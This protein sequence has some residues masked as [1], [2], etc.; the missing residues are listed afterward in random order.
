MLKELNLKFDFKYITI[1]MTG[2]GTGFYH[3]AKE[4]LG[5]RVIG[6]NFASRVNINEKDVD[7]YRSKDVNRTKKG[8]VTIP[9]KRAMAT[10]MKVEAE[11]GKLIILDYNDYIADM[12][13]VPYDTLDAPRSK[14]GAHG[15]E[16]WGSALAIWGYH[17]NTA[18]KAFMKP[19][20]MRY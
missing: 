12:H 2:P 5:N 8:K 9:V 6:I 17:Q 11:K 14:D 15:D 4:Q 20:T 7:M 10:Q 18:M 13:S 1:D 19:I 3:Y 16:F